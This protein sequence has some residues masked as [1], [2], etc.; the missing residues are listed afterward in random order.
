MLIGL[1]GIVMADAF[2]SYRVMDRGSVDL[3]TTDL[4]RVGVDT[5]FAQAILNEFIPGMPLTE[6]LIRE[7]EA[8]P[9]FI[10]ILSR[11]IFDEKNRLSGWM[12]LELEHA[13]QCGRRIVPVWLDDVKYQD[14][15]VRDS[16]GVSCQEWLAL[17]TQENSAYAEDP[18]WQK[19][20]R[21]FEPGSGPSLIELSTA[22][23]KA[24]LTDDWAPLLSWLG[25]MPGAVEPVRQQRITNA[26][27]E[28]VDRGFMRE[29]HV[30]RR[31]DQLRQHIED[32]IIQ[33]QRGYEI[34]RRTF[35]A[36][37]Y[38]APPPNPS[39][40]VNRTL[41]AEALSDT[42]SRAEA[43]LRATRDEKKELNDKLARRINEAQ[44]RDQ[45]LSE[46]RRKAAESEESTRAMAEKLKVSE[47]ERVQAQNEL[48]VARAELLKTK[49]ALDHERHTNNGYMAEW[50]FP[51]EIS[52][53]IS[54]ARHESVRA[55]IARSDA[56]SCARRARE[57][58]AKSDRD[59]RQL[60]RNGKAGPTYIGDDYENIVE[61]EAFG[62]VRW[63]N[64]IEYAGAIS[65]NGAP[66]GSGVINYNNGR[67]YMGRV[68]HGMPDEV[69]VMISVG[70]EGDTWQGQWSQ[71]RPCGLGA[72]TLADGK[73][74]Y[75]GEIELSPS[76]VLQ[77]SGMGILWDDRRQAEYATAAEWKADVAVRKFKATGKQRTR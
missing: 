76:G 74:L 47:Q 33:S 25:K 18:G 29:P 28:M 70:V 17:R 4:R 38:E 3:L 75:E 63:M 51:I 59:P 36:G 39:T 19:L 66:E 71:G 31:T 16:I 20:L 42:V 23:A 73:Q 49:S 60:H 21:G 64:G 50:Q 43:E 2:V 11:Q 24:E 5:F 46:T 26:I 22:I 12:N 14:P 30:R 68:R 41:G 77:F 55:N 57:A 45:E 65:R 13:D 48:M 72:L 9:V 37:N 1:A 35:E 58:A 10:M 32:Q 27:V 53:K 54:A 8:A 62:I 34:W 61:G 56:E 40:V 7:I 69:G 44:T 15:R 67:C 6:T 52:D